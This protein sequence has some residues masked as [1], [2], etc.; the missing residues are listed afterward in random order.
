[1][2]TKAFIFHHLL[3]LAQTFFEL[4]ADAPSFDYAHGTHLVAAMNTC[5]NGSV[6]QIPVRLPKDDKEVTAIVCCEDYDKLVAITPKWR[7]SSKGYVVSSRRVEGKNV[8]TYMHRVIKDLPGRHLNGDKLDNRRNNL[9][10]TNRGAPRNREPEVGLEIQTIS[11][12]LDFAI[13]ASDVPEKG[14]H[15]TVCY[16]PDMSYSGEI[17]NYRPHGFGTLVERN[18]TSMG[19]WMQGVFKSGV[20]MQLKPVPEIMKKQFVVPQIQYA[21]LVVNEEKVEVSLD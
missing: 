5:S 1:M 2:L 8:I 13:P 9:I 16:S 18:K 15:C 14:K 17:M 12:V 11:P 3:A 10:P 6:C 20:V 21:V 19:W 7:L 4:K